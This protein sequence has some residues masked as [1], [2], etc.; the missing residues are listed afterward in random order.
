MAKVL[1]CIALLLFD[2]SSADTERLDESELMR[3]CKQRDIAYVKDKVKEFGPEAVLEAKEYS[4]HCFITMLYWG[5]NWGSNCKM[6]YSNPELFFKGAREKRL[7][8]EREV[9]EKCA[10]EQTELALYLLE[11]G[12]DV[13]EVTVN[14]GG[15]SAISLATSYGNI[16]MM[17]MLLDFGA[18]TEIADYEG[19][20]AVFRAKNNST[21]SLLMD[22]GANIDAKDED[23]K[24]ALRVALCKSGD[25]LL[26]AMCK[27]EFEWAVMFLEHG[28]SYK[29]AHDAK[30]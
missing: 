11:I 3:R 23:G 6:D 15:I 8:K 14:D 12:A 16:P 29:L 7:Q 21:L 19:R 5:L 4:K 27:K 24:T 22:N 9:K 25:D 17:K 18:D 10:Q 28:A 1:Y 20:T 13:N 26:A 2:W 30:C